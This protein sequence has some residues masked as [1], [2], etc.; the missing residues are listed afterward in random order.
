MP[1]W[2][3]CAP[4]S[5]SLRPAAPA[6]R[7]AVLLAGD[8]G[9]GKTRLL[10]ELR[11]RAVAD[12]WLVLAGHCL[13]FGDSALPYLPFSEII[14]RLA[15]ELP[16]LFD[17]VAERHPALLR[18]LPGQRMLSQATDP[19]S[20]PAD[21]AALFDAVHALPRRPAPASPCSSSSRTS[22]GPTS[23]PATCSA[24]CSP[25]ASTAPVALVASYR[26]DDLHR[27]HP[28]RRQVAEWARM[29]GVERVQLEPL[30]RADVRRLVQQLHPD[31]LP[32][33]RVRDIVGRAEGNAFFVEELV[34]ATR[35]RT[36]R[37]PDDLADAAPGPA[38]PSL[39][40]AAR[41]VVRAAARGRPPGLPRRCS[42]PSSTS[43][44]PSSTGPCAT[45]S[46]ATCWCRAATTSTRSGTPCSPRR[47][48]TTSCPAS[49]PAARGVRRGPARTAAPAAP[50]PSW[51]AT[52]GSPRTTRPRSP[53]ACGPATTRAGV[54]GAEEAAQ[55]YL[56]ALELWH[57]TRL[58]E[59]AADLDHPR[60]VGL[61]ADALI[62][63]GHPAR[64]LG[65]VREQLDHLPPDAADAVRG[66]LLGVARRRPG[67]D[68]DA[69]G[70]A[71]RSPPR[72]SALV[73]RRARPPPGPRCWPCTPGCW[74]A[75]ATY[76]EGREVAMTALALAERLDMPRLASDIRTTLVGLERRAARPSPWSRRCAPA[77]DQARPTPAP[78][79]PSCAACSCSATTTSTRGEFAE[80]DE[81]FTRGH[82]PGQGGGHARGCP[83]PPRRAGC[84]P[85]RCE[86]QGRWDDALRVLDTS[87]ARSSPPIYRRA[88]ARRTRAADPGRPAATPAGERAGPQ[89]AARSGAQEGLVAI[90]G[91]AAELD[92]AR[93]RP[94]TRR[95]RSRPTALIVETLTG[96][97][98]PLFQARVRLAATTLA[99]FAPGAAHRSATERAADA[100]ARGRPGRRRARRARPPQRDVR[101]VVGPREPRLGGAAATPSCCGW[102]WVGRRRPAAARG[103]GRRPG[104]RPVAASR[105]T[106]RPTSWPRVRAPLAEVLAAT[107]DADGARELDRGRG[108]DRPSSSGAAAAAAPLGRAAA[109]PAPVAPRPAGDA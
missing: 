27:R 70:P 24:S 95:P 67:H 90:T 33:E 39:D 7:A 43:S 52:P 60:L 99:A 6:D 41:Q 58:P 35:T 82:D 81:A 75:P 49:G 45:P 98:H 23:P 106:A 3:S 69:A 26:S 50:P 88:A 80:A 102:R 22:T 65:V 40:D 92:A 63:A 108:R 2:S 36:G 83:T 68:R 44:P 79:T 56:Q 107:G 74:P 94:A 78:P 13:D 18:L 47:S 32:E 77:I 48:T 15:R 31:P 53:R 103:A 46:R 20:V 66:Q 73:A 14:G 97:W 104:A 85:C 62:A 38:R 9:V 105:R 25:A 28:L 34:G 4:R 12:G 17:E 100:D 71:R 37:I 64:A 30:R 96:I 10:T 61:V 16:D 29:P 19:E 84:T 57:D 11:D 55:H 5:A 93:A 91:G 76:E 86:M 51:P 1:S 59:R 8:A 21:Q 54:G 89:P 72:P 87:S 101:H 109:P 42:A